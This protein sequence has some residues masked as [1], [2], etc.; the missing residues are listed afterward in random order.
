MAQLKD[1]VVS[2]NLRVTDTTLTDTLQVTKIKAPTTAGGTTYGPGS[3][4]QVLKSNGETAYWASDSNSDV[5]VTQ[6]ATTTDAA[7][8]VLFSNT[9]DNTTRTETARKNS[10]LK[11]NP[12]T[13][14]LY[15]T[16]VYA[17]GS[18]SQSA[19]PSG[20][21]HVYDCRSVGV[22]PAN[23][24]KTANFYFHMTDTPD[25]SKWWS[26]M[27][28]KGWVGAYS[29][30]EI[31]GPA[32]NSD[33]RTTPLYVR[34]SN[35]STA[36]GSWRKIY[37]TSNKP[38]ASEI[39][40]LS[41]STNYA[42]STSVG[43]NAILADGLA[44][45]TLTA[46]TL[47]TTTGSFV[48]KGDHL[49]GATYDWAGLQ[50]DASNDAFQL[51]ANGQ[52]MFRQN[53]STSKT[54]E[55][56]GEWKG[57][58]SPSNV[59]G[60][61][62]I[63]VTQND[64]TIGSGDDAYSYK[65]AVT[66]SHSNSITQELSTVFKKFSYDG[67]G[68]I[69]GVA[70]VLKADITAL[71]IPAQD[72]TYGISG[73]YGANNNT[74]VTTIT[75]G[76]TGTTSTVPTASTSAYGITKLYNGVDS[77]S[78]GLAA[79]ANAVKTA[80][81]KANH[82]HPYLPSTTTYAGSSSVGG[83]ATNVNVTDLNANAD[84]ATYYPTFV[85]SNG[86]QALKTNTTNGPR[87]RHEPGT[88]S[89][90]GIARIMLGNATTSGTAGNAKGQIAFYSESSGYAMLEYATS[91][92]NS[93][94][95][96]PA[97]ASGTYTLAVTSDIPTTYAGSATAGGI[98]NQA[99]YLTNE[100]LVSTSMTYGSEKFEWYDLSANQGNDPTKKQNPENDWFHHTTMHHKNNAGY[101]FDIAYGFN[102][103]AIYYR[104][105]QNGA[106]KG[107]VRLIDSSNIGSQTVSSAATLSTPRN[108]SLG[109]GVASTATAFDGS[110]DI[111]IPVTGIKEA[112]LTWGGKDFTQSFSPL[113]AAL[114]PRLG[115]NRLEMCP[116]TGIKI[117]RTTDGGTTWTEVT[118]SSINNA[119]RSTL[120][121]S[122]AG[123]S[124]PVSATSTAS[125]GTDAAK[126]MMRITLDTSVANV[127]TN[128]VKFIFNVST[129]GCANCYVKLR[130]RTAANVTAGND[131]WL[132]WDKT[133]KTWSSSPAE[134]DTR[135]PIGGWS[136]YNVINFTSF[137]TYGN[138][139]SQY[140][141]IQF[142]FGCTKNDSTSAGLAVINI[143][144]YGGVAWN[145][146]SNMARTGHLY[147]WT[148]TGAATFPSSVTA[149]GNLIASSASGDS[150][151]LIFK[152]GTYV[153]NLNDWKIYVSSGHLYFDQSTANASSETWT[154]KMYYHASNGNLYIGSS[155][156]LHAGNY[157]S[158]TYSS[159]ASR[160][161]NYVLAAPNGSAG[162]ATFRQLVAADLPSH[163][164]QYAGSASVG[165]PAS[166]LAYGHTNEI[167][168]SGGKQSTC[169]FNYRDADT[170]AQDEGETPVSINYKFCNYRNSTA[171]T[172][173]TAA[174][175]SGNASTATKWQTAR[176]LTIGS[177]GK[178]V[179]GSG[180]VSWSLSEIGA[181]PSVSGGY[182]P[183]SG[184]TMTGP[185]TMK[186]NQY[187]GAY[188]LDMSNS[189]IIGAN[190]IIFADEAAVTEGLAFWRSASTTD[191]F[192]IKAGEMYFTP[193][194]PTATTNYTVLHTG[195][196]STYVKASSNNGKISVN[197]SDV[198]VYTHPTATAQSSGLYKITVD[199]TGH[200]TAAT[201]A[202]PY[203]GAS[204]DGGAATS[205]NTLALK[206]LAF[207][208]TLNTTTGL[209]AY[210]TTGSIY[211]TNSADWVG[212]QIGSSADRFQIM[213]TVG[214][215]VLIRTNDASDSSISTGWS[216]WSALMTP[217]SVIAGSGLTKTY[218]Y[219]D[220]TA[221]SDII[222]NATIGHSNSVTAQTSTVFKKFSY[223]ACGHITGADAVA[224]ADI[225]QLDYIGAKSDGSYWGMTTPA[226]DD[227]QW[228]RTS[229]RGIIP[230]QLR[231]SDS[232]AT[233]NTNGSTCYLGTS[234]W[235][236]AEAF[237]QEIHGTSFSG[238]AATA[239]RLKSNSSV[240]IT[241]GVQ[242]TSGQKT[243]GTADG[244]AAEGSNA[245]Y[246][247][248]SYPA[249]G[250]YVSGGVANIQTLRL[251]WNSTYF[252]DIFASPNYKDLYHRAVVNNTANAWRKIL[253]STNY[254]DY[255]V[256]SLKTLTAATL[257]TTEGSYVFGGTNLLGGVND[258][259]GFQADAGNDRF[260][261]IAN[262][263]LM[264]R[265]NDAASISGTWGDW[266]GCLT[267]NNVSGDTGITI[268]ATATHIGASDGGMDY[269]SG[270]KI[271]HTNSITAQTSTVFKKFKYDAQGHITGVDT[272]AGTDLPSHKHT[273]TSGGTWIKAR[274]NANLY[275]NPPTNSGSYYPAIFAKTK[276][277][278][279]SMGVL[280]GTSTTNDFYV[281]YT[282]DA[283]YT[284]DNNTNT[285]QITFPKDSGTL[286]LTK[287]H[288]AKSG[289][290][291]T[292]L[293]TMYRE[294]TTTQNYPA[295][296]K[297]SVKDTT[298]GQT[299]NSDAYIYA[300]Q[301]HASTTYG[302]NMVINPG[303]CMFIGAGESAGA[304]YSAIKANIGTSEWM[305][306]TAD[307]GIYLQGKG[308][309]IA[310][311]C[312]MYITGSS[313]ETAH[314]IVPC[315]ADTLTN[316][317]GSIGTQTYRWGYMFATQFNGKLGQYSSAV[318]GENGRPTSANVA[319]AGDRT[320]QL[321]QATSKMTTAKPSTDGYILNF[322]WDSTDGYQSQLFIANSVGLNSIQHRTQG[323]SA[324]W[325]NSRWVTVLTQRNS[326][327][328]N[329]IFDRY[330]RTPAS[331][332]WIRI[333]TI[334]S[335]NNNGRVYGMS[336]ITI[337]RTYSNNAPEILSFEVIN[338]YNTSPN[339]YFL[340]SLQQSTGS[341]VFTNIRIVKS[342]DGKEQYVDIYHNVSTQNY[343]GIRYE[344]FEPYDML[345]VNNNYPITTP[346]DGTTL[347][348]LSTSPASA[349][350]MRASV[351][352]PLT[353]DNN[354]IYA[355][356]Y[357]GFAHRDGTATSYLRTTSNGLL[358]YQSGNVGSGHSNIGTS[359]WYFSN[360]YVDTVNSQQVKIKGT[361]TYD[362]TISNANAT[363]NR[364]VILPDS[365][366]V[367]A[368]M[369]VI[370]D[371]VQGETEW[372]FSIDANLYRAFI[373]E[374]ILDGYTT[375][376]VTIDAHKYYPAAPCA[377]MMHSSR[378]TSD[379]SYN[380]LPAWIGLCYNT[381]DTSTPTWQFYP[382]RASKAISL[383]SG[384]GISS[385]S[386]PNTAVI[387]MTKIIGLTN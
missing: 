249:D 265:Q 167:N 218:G 60:S 354:L 250:T 352:T 35:A 294:G 245:S 323:G 5:N 345:D 59:V 103:N 335:F 190:R 351:A 316:N 235:Y 162:A 22:T 136:G 368:L 298:T 206:S 378:N 236:F 114:E 18:E 367:I 141:N 312:G 34:T 270:V 284:A 178:S 123:Y 320:V 381:V 99:H 383:G 119:N 251:Y 139:T 148:G 216:K 73:A 283:N 112:Y 104:R 76:G 205:A 74:W 168:I 196:L 223:D 331:T 25:T 257:N 163:T 116:G 217:A 256:Q 263:Q 71:G 11:F 120:F 170:D 138:N 376:T 31:A 69:T 41:S 310:N 304:H 189:D 213:G 318:L 285:Y 111:T 174:N 238:T 187:S 361:G 94:F 36:W 67:N 9:A 203:A 301:D 382:G 360:I 380:I 128:L 278:G 26:V 371:N 176:T 57:C 199:G 340:K 89:A 286:A 77:T 355:N 185:L 28:V 97:K 20:G 140:R 17:G 231:A 333:L 179:D 159:T 137:T 341:R 132:T 375:Q 279:W 14:S 4:G 211:G 290:T 33:Q 39:G 130:I 29:A 169:Y 209:F 293:L 171:N 295:G 269:L 175:F 342:S 90:V 344:I 229:K 325:E 374:V 124:V 202:G 201:A 247:L 207:G 321:I 160:T 96:F 184:G 102:T 84:A 346:S 46:E 153:D 147:S 85:S 299:Y 359:S 61:S 183:L 165:G 307:A 300:Y 15:A 173:I 338:N 326:P 222:I 108:I 191:N 311:R 362:G 302:T 49:L 149:T 258:W 154:H 88:T 274:D 275:V 13:G 150:P 146:P 164:H 280:G 19:Y 142:I 192:W 131:T 113:D 232:T 370:L 228:I 52:L 387:K 363:D 21:Y 83:A 297:F 347:T 319:T 81:D 37:D 6:T 303:G 306:L 1:S 246:K 50:V 281:T 70:N 117:E 230:Y 373:I 268:T 182:L 68:H 134:A 379:S 105:V 109:T 264:F 215:T 332:G 365:S 64:I 204:S 255:A 62:G 10:N 115:A 7:Y 95:Q 353:Y 227:S 288:V 309:S 2:G 82:S 54:S 314:Q 133:N 121:S 40:A 16:I 92:A 350:I 186:A 193:N 262:N 127:Y 219:F 161:A 296:F 86:S 63:T 157:T 329:R 322:D 44:M 144:G 289:D 386:V 282:T 143:Q 277:G 243:V 87:F 226:N 225:P 23:G 66:I 330:Y 151:A 47:D 32:H 369:N 194:Y 110:A 106:D 65:G 180:N 239:D 372:E 287:N 38:T 101:Y 248:W 212:M 292:G 197:G 53:D 237:I 234:T 55:N 107:W 210:T 271:S 220:G 252:R 80:Y 100:R 42:L 12:S 291:M 315:V 244:N 181:A 384:G 27:H 276:D 221:D 198:T 152:R 267:P 308:N 260:Q 122:S 200:V 366:G 58:L 336:R 91:T 75:A 261:I 337:T 43:G 208:S 195:N 233:D 253:D 317:V 79:T 305:Y 72:T 377:F 129:N 241:N 98:A 254:T 188:G 327:A 272:V 358:P 328:F 135:C 349:D 45:K 357:W 339:I 3:N 242:Y 273:S 240:S 259:V 56:W 48:F 158:Y 313:T 385:V 224:K 8:E 78:T 334:G 166:L 145:A 24:D 118:T 343:I 51:M 364:T 348:V 172:T 156:V 93:T 125:M 214:S 324:T 266:L 356:S 30:W 155:I 126:Y 177:T